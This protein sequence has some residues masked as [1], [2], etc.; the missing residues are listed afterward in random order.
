MNT[1]IYLLQLSG[2]SNYIAW[3]YFVELFNLDSQQL[4]H[5]RACPKLSMR[6]IQ[7]D[8]TAKMR[9]RLVTQVWVKRLVHLH[10]KTKLRPN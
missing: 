5:A 9:V 7:L 1:F 2:E 8:N 10:A 4:G 3:K 6:H